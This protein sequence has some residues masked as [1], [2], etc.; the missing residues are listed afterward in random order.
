M[1]D[2]MYKT[3]QASS[4]KSLHWDL[5][6]PPIKGMGMAFK[7]KIVTFLFSAKSLDRAK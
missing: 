4:I 7:L 5:G 3:Q 6:G 2:H 1:R